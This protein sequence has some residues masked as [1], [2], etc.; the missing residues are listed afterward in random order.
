MPCL[1]NNDREEGK[2]VCSV[3]IAHKVFDW[4]ERKTDW[5]NKSDLLAGDVIQDQPTFGQPL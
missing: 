3:K 2:I 4:G 5:S 1:Q